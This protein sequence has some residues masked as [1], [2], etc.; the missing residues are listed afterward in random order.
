MQGRDLQLQPKS[1]W[2]M[3]AS[4]GGGALA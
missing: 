2:D 1:E 3:L 4:W